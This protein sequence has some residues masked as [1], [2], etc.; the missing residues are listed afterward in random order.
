MSEGV[1]ADSEAREALKGR[2]LSE[3]SAT[4]RGLSRAGPLVRVGAAQAI[5]A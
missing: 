5:A 4:L 1:L 2:M 3:D